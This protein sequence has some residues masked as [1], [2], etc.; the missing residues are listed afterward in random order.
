MVAL[1]HHKD[2]LPMLETIKGIHPHTHTCMIYIKPNIHS[3]VCG[4]VNGKKNKLFTLKPS[5]HSNI[6]AL[7]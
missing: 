1:D 6:L 2:L 7:K 5:L 4:K 3:K